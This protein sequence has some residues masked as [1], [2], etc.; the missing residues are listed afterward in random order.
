[1]RMGSL[2]N[3]KELASMTTPGRHM[4]IAPTSRAGHGGALAAAG[5]QGLTTN[6]ST[7]RLPPAAAMEWTNRARAARAA[8]APVQILTGQ[9]ALA[10]EAMSWR[11]HQ[12]LQFLT[13]RLRCHLNAEWRA[14]GE[15]RPVEEVLRE[16]QEVH[17]V[18]LTVDGAIVRR[19]AS[20]PSKAVAALLTKLDLWSLFQ[21]VENGRTAPPS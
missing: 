4:E 17:R 15:K 7:D 5:F 6:V 13:H 11:N 9:P 19:L 14:R 3:L 1:M 10:E 16:L 2:A 12:N 8:F 20:H 21:S 18:T